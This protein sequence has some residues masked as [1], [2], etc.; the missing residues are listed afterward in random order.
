[1]KVEK[2]ILLIMT[3]LTPM[4]TFAHDPGGYVMS[5]GIV[6]FLSLII[7]FF[8]LKQ[9]SHSINI[10]NKF[11]KFVV[12]FVIEIMLLFLLSIVLFMTIGIL[13]YIN[14]FNG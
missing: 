12:L 3:L 11:V 5:M 9:I 8:L 7:S 14:I 1:M 10:N 4:A 6:F 13:I 2:I